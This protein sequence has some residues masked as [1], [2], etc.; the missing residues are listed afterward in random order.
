M[1]FYIWWQWPWVN[2]YFL[3]FYKF[4]FHFQFFQLFKMNIFSLIIFEIWILFLT[5]LW[6]W[7][8][9]DRRMFYFKK[10]EWS[11]LKKKELKIIQVYL[12][13][14]FFSGP[15][16]LKKTS[17]VKPSNRLLCLTNKI[18]NCLQICKDVLET[19]NGVLY[20]I[21]ILRMLVYFDILDYLSS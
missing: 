11:N 21:V 17:K 10:L 7:N 12:I 9:D 20:L 8:F 15:S 1:Q 3:F 6:F 2:G 19:R 14:Y 18:L 5:N 4:S 16:F 13:S